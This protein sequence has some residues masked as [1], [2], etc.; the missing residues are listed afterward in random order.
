MANVNAKRASYFIG[1]PKQ[2]VFYFTSNDMAFFTEQA[3][4]STAANL[5][6]QGKSGAIDVVTRA[7]AAAW[8]NTP[9]GTTAAPAATPS[10]APAATTTAAAPAA[11][12]TTTTAAT[13]ASVQ[14]V[15]DGLNAQIA[16]AN[17]ALD[18][19]KLAKDNLPATASALDKRNA[20]TAVNKA[21][22]TIADLQVKLD[23]ATAQLAGLSA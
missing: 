3:A 13:A 4:S 18:S 1:H 17:T 23:D 15:I 12:T 19:A 16:V 20:T 21:A 11:T 22:A 8:V 14:A 10:A 7:D 9:N 2:D 6:K 5:A